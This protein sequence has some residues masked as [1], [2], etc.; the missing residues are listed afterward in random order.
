MEPRSSNDRVSAV[1]RRS[2]LELT[3]GALG[4]SAATA[5][6][7]TGGARASVFPAASRVPPDSYDPWIEILGDA[8]RHNV[9]EA[10]RLAGV[11][12]VLRG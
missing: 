5:C 10:S 4:L 12:R 2:F 1:P 6:G 9:R 3:V 11:R 8:Y 7:M